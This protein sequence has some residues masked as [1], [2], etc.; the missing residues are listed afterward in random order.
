[1]HNG[2]FP[3][4]VPLN[5]QVLAAMSKEERSF[6]LNFLDE[7]ARTVQI[8]AQDGGARNKPWDPPE[9]L[10]VKYREAVEKYSGE[11]YCQ[12]RQLAELFRF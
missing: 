6:W 12:V 1:M 4:G 3:R 5:G 9:S 8:F 7:A 2:A 10:R 11:Q